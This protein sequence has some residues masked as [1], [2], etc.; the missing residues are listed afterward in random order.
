MYFIHQSH[1]GI[2]TQKRPLLSRHC[3]LTFFCGSLNGY[4]IAFSCR[5]TLLFAHE[6]QETKVKWIL[7]VD[8]MK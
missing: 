8:K 3:N 5:T 1:F 4:Q 7:D 2:V 6:G